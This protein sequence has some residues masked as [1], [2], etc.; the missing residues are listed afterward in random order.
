LVNDTSPKRQRGCAKYEPSPG[1]RK[2]AKKNKRGESLARKKGAS[3]VKRGPKQ[4]GGKGGRSGDKRNLDF[5]WGEKGGK[6]G[7]IAETERF[8]LAGAGSGEK[9]LRR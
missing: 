6:G 3:W 5:I 4:V 9:I 1:V 8:D 7:G 2:R